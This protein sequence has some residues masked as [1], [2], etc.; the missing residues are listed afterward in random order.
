MTIR[1]LNGKVP[2]S[3]L[4]VYGEGK[5]GLIGVCDAA[6]TVEDAHRDAREWL[7]THYTGPYAEAYMQASCEIEVGYR[8]I[9]NG[10]MARRGRNG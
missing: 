6:D 8:N 1:T 2:W 10:G 5:L 3:A 7:R 4:F 9:F